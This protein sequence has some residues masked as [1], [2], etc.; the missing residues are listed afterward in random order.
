MQILKKIGGGGKILLL[1]HGLLTLGIQLSN[2]FVNIYL[3]RVSKDLQVLAIFNLFLFSVVPITFLFSGWLARNYDRLWC[4]RIGIIIHTIF[5]LIVLLIKQDTV[6]YIIPLGMFKGIGVGFY[7]L[8]EHVLVFDLTEDNTRDY[9]NGINGFSA[10]FFGMIAPFISGLIINNLPDLQGYMVI[11]G[12]TVGL[13]IGVEILS[14]FIHPR[15]CPGPY[16]VWKVLKN[17]DPNWRRVLGIIGFYGIRTGIFSF[18]TALLVFL[19][20]GRE[21]ILGS[22][23]L[24]MGVLTLISAYALAYLVKPD[25]RPCYIHTSSIMLVGALLVLLWRSD[26]IGILVFGVL[27]GIFDPFFDIPFESLSF[28]VIE[29]D[30]IDEDLR[31]EYIVARE[32]PLNLGRILSILLFYLLLGHEMDVTRLRI[33]LAFLIPAPIIISILLRGIK[34]SNNN[35]G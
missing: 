27:T 12:I 25:K 2:I 31:I 26:W 14:F 9:F 15:F 23:S 19:A 21:F 16:C 24:G 3:W 6:N 30:T 18:L 22:F 13:F 11:F 8:A 35:I 10:S 17:P 7:H 29:T 5:Y 4:I 20:S 1:V 32:I 28:K 34:F 33:Y